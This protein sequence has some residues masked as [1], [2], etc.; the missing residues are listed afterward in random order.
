MKSNF[1]NRPISEFGKHKE[2]FIYA[3]DMFDKYFNKLKEITN[4]FRLTQ[5]ESLLNEISTLINICNHLQ[6]FYIQNYKRFNLPEIKEVNLL[7]E[8]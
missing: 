4:E 5:D 2:E 1:M 8:I 6:T 7:E 3:K